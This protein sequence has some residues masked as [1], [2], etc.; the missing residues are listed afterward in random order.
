[1]SSHSCPAYVPHTS[2]IRPEYVPNLSQAR[3]APARRFSI[4]VKIERLYTELRQ[5]SCGLL[6]HTP[7]RCQTDEKCSPQEKQQKIKEIPA[8]VGCVLC[9]G[10][11]GPAAA[12]AAGALRA[13][14]SVRG[15][16]TKS[17]GRPRR[18]SRWEWTPRPKTPYIQSK[19]PPQGGPLLS[20][21]GHITRWSERAGNRESS[22]QQIP[23]APNDAAPWPR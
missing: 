9:G 11:K 18:R 13:P 19:G 8:P 17:E 6:R 14:V 2:R 7:F 15:T 3:P 5:C 12:L 20:E 21:M 1:M 4:S 23:E 10:F 22:S 16:L